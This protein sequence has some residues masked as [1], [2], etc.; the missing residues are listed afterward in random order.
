MMALVHTFTL[1]SMQH[2]VH[3]HIQHIV[4][5]NNNIADALSHFKMDRFWQL[6]PHTEA[7]PLPMANIW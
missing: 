2:I 1:L 4:G 7:E 5:V 6:C 3:V